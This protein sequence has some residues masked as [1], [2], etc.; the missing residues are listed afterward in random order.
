MPSELPIPSR[1]ALLYRVEVTVSPLLVREMPQVIEAFT[2]QW[3][4]PE[5]IERARNQDAGVL[6]L[7]AEGHL[8]AGE[9]PAELARQITFAIWQSLGRYVK[10]TAETTYLGDPPQSSFEFGEDA[11]TRAY[12]T[13]FEN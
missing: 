6:M 9:K 10:V 7:S 12:E 11:Y 2:L 1:N 8:R 3:A 13:R 5:E 4:R